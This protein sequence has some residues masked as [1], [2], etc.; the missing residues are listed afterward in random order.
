MPTHFCAYTV[1]K[2]DA[3]AHCGGGD[4]LDKD[5]I[6]SD[7]WFGHQL[8]SKIAEYEYNMLKVLCVLYIVLSAVDAI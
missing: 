4:R 8:D 1:N 7:V 2:L 6:G 3:A 5:T